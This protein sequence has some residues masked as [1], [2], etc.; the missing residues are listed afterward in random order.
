MFYVFNLSSGLFTGLGFN[1]HP[2]TD[3]AIAVNTPKGCGARELDP[4]Q[5][6]RVRVDINTG[7][8]LPYEPPQ[9]S[10][11]V[12]RRVEAQYASERRLS[13]IHALEAGQHRALRSLAIDPTDEIA[14]QRLVDIEAQIAALRAE[15]QPQV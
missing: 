6:G 2:R 12:Q 13:Q 15:S 10:A 3:A 14:K 4:S 7:E 5:V 11:E 8:L 1:V 9:P